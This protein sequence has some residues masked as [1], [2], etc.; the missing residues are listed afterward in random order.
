MNVGKTTV[1]ASHGVCAVEDVRPDHRSTW[2]R[3]G[4]AYAGLRRSVSYHV[5]RATDVARIPARH[6]S[7][8][9]GKSRQAVSYGIEEHPGAL[10]VVGRLEPARLAHLSRTGDATDRP[11]PDAL[12]VRVAG[13]RSRG[14]GLCARFHNDRPVL[15][16]VRLGTVSQHQGS[17][18]DA[19]AAGS[20]WC[21]SCLHSR[22]RRQ[23]ARRWRARSTLRIAAI[24]TSSDC[25]NSIRRGLSSLRAPNGT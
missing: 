9:D 16:S 4:S 20:A 21:D 2:R 10:D 18:Q 11:G 22:E 8:P 7:L 5:L 14:D 23:D 13:H 6:R 17:G 12:C 19:H 24:S 15:V 1:R 3:R 25:T